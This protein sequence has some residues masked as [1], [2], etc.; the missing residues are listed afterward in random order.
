[1]VSGYNTLLLFLD[2]VDAIFRQR[3]SIYTKKGVLL[4]DRGLELAS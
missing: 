3:R 1:M 2:K 4:C